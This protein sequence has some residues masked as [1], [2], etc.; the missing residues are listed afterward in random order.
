M[1]KLINKKQIERKNRINNTFSTENDVHMY[2]SVMSHFTRLSVDP[3]NNSETGK[4][5][6]GKNCIH[7][8]ERSGEHNI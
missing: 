8:R 1:L 7:H 2:V 3:S 4:T 6:I 5:I